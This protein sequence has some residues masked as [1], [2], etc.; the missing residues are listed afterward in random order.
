MQG[1]MVQSDT[2]NQTG[3]I[4]RQDR[5][6]AY[7]DAEYFPFPFEKRLI[8]IDRLVGEDDGIVHPA[9]LSKKGGNGLNSDTRSQQDRRL[10]YRSLC[11]GGGE[12]WRSVLTYN[13]DPIFAG[14]PV[15]RFRSV[16]HTAS[17]SPAVNRGDFAPSRKL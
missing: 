4:T 5:G 13:R 16:G 1:A 2:L 15:G 7:V 17:P 3:I 14:R 12:F 6:T 10:K 9:R 8:V 11:K